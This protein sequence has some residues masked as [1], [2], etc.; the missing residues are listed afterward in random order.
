MVRPMLRLSAHLVW[1]WVWVW[2]A[3]L[4]GASL[5]EEAEAQA[6]R[7]ISMRSY[8]RGGGGKT[9]ARTIRG[10]KQAALS[11]AR[12]FGKRDSPLTLPLAVPMARDDLEM[13]ASQ[14]QLNNRDSLPLEW[15]LEGMQSNPVLARLFFQRLIEL[16]HDATAA[17][18]LSSNEALSPLYIAEK[19]KDDPPQRQDPDDVIM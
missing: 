17:A 14:L 9:P 3:M 15:V 8:Y 2:V 5:V 7:S 6:Q 1:V 11:T 16:N 10:F 12:G 18:E 19:S 4:I 13:A